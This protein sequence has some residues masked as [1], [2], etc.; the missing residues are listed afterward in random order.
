MNYINKFL[1]SSDIFNSKSK[2]QQLLFE[3]TLEDLTIHHKNRCSE[4]STF[5]KKI[6]IKK[7]NSNQ[8]Y[9]LPFLPVQIFKIRKLVSVKENEIFKTLSSSGTT[10]NKKS[11]I[12]LDKINS[13]NQ[14]KAL[15][16]ILSQKFGKQRK[17]ML[18]IEKDPTHSDKKKFSA[19]LAAL[20]GFS[21]LASKQFYLLKQ[22]GEVNFDVLKIFMER[23][24]NE[25]F[26]IF[27]FTSSVYKKFYEKINHHSFD[28]SNA[29]LIHGGGWKKLKDLNI[30]NDLF[31]KKIKD[32]LNISKIFNYYGLIEQTGSIFFECKNGFFVSS[33]FSDVIIRDK[34]FN[35]L[36][37]NKKGLIQ[38]VSI[39]PTSYPGHSIITEDIGEVVKIKCSCGLNGTHFKVHGRAKEAEIR[40]CSDA[41]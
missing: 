22:N 24:A 1:E 30:S 9:N 21:I 38:L 3:N 28:F 31:K 34:N 2:K 26:Y 8:L 41:R 36:E 6:N 39:L 15:N 14:T 27:G 5:V 11:K 23:F 7:N 33:I 10:N 37:N 16:K 25:K 40:G 29:T 12:Y 4:Y 18:F 19:S 13:Q 32:K 20:Y 35:V 17:P